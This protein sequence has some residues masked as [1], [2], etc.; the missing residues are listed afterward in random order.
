MFPSV[1][2]S[3]RSTLPTIGNLGLDKQTCLAPLSKPLAVAKLSTA[4]RPILVSTGKYIV[5]EKLA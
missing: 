2:Q 3:S 1:S 5:E 4:A